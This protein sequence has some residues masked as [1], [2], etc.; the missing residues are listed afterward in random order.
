MSSSTD[1]AQKTPVQANATTT[2]A[3]SKAS[4]PTTTAATAARVVSET[5]TSTSNLSI[6]Q[7][8]HLLASVSGMDKPATKRKRGSLDQHIGFSVKGQQPAVEL[9]RI[10]FIGAGNM[11]RAIAEGWISSGMWGM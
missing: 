4:K 10:G 3:A 5:S 8:L 7:Q 6:N 2:A 1:S 9:R 11:A